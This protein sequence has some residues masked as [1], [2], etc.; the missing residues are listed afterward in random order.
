[1]IGGRVKGILGGV[2]VGNLGI[3]AR[4]Y[5]SGAI[6]RGRALVF[7]KLNGTD[8]ELPVSYQFNRFVCFE[9]LSVGYSKLKISEINVGK[10]GG[11]YELVAGGAV[12]AACMAQGLE[13]LLKAVCAG[14]G[15]KEP[16][17]QHNLVAMFDVAIRQ[18][19]FQ[20]NLNEILTTK[21]IPTPETSAREVV[22]QVSKAWMGSRYLGLKTDAIE[23][24]STEKLGLV[25]L[26]LMVSF[27]VKHS[28]AL[29]EI[30][31]L[32]VNF[33]FSDDAK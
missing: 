19:Q 24:P 4:N 18:G 22:E 5:I 6:L 10:Q 23:L 20:N 31:N 8:L 33:V 25:I 12:G 7:V 21:N 17:G 29:S 2:V 28:L 3:Y 16:S 1:M 11:A 27:F 30:L 32:D 9:F 15:V 26:A 13:L 14:C